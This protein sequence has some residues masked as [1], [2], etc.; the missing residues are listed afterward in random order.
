MALV[1]T[2]ADQ[3]AGQDGLRGS[4]G[5]T[6]GADDEPVPGVSYTDLLLLVAKLL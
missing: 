2:W 4:P 5:V 6:R 3:P 1:Q